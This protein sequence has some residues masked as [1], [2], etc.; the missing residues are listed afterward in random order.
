M[1]E[2][3]VLDYLS[4]SL[5]VPV[6]MEEPENPPKSYLILEKTGSSE[7][8]FIASA[9]IAGQS[10]AERLYKAAQL[11]QLVK[12]AMREIT[13]LNSVCRCNLNGDYNFTDT[14]TKRYRYQAVFDI[15][16]YEE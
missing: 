3:L 5:D 12:Q 8:N 10:Y 14:D 11:N 1:I 6:Y 13:N 2:K 15:T 16:F 9:T 4:E 7:A